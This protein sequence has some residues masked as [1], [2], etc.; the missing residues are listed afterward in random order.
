MA[1]TDM[2]WS[3]QSTY[4]KFIRELSLQN[5]VYTESL[6][7]HQYSPCPAVIGFF[8][9]TVGELETLLPGEFSYGFDVD[10]EI[11]ET[12]NKTLRL[13]VI[14]MEFSSSPQ[15]P[16]LYDA[17]KKHT[18]TLAEKQGEATRLYCMALECGVNHRDAHPDNFL[19]D[20]KGRLKLI[21]FGLARQLTEKEKVIPLIPLI[22]SDDCDELRDALKDLYKKNAWFLREPFSIDSYA[23]KISKKAV[24][25]CAEGLC[26]IIPQVDRRSEVEKIRMDTKAQK[27]VRE[28]TR[29]E[30]HQERLQRL[31]RETNLPKPKEGEE[32]RLQRWERERTEGTTEQDRRWARELEEER[33]VN[34]RSRA[35]RIL[36][37]DHVHRQHIKNMSDE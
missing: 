3:S 5:H 34:R 7:K 17:V 13:G 31:E 11:I 25:R 30:G 22:A 6:R 14:F 20:D 16:T 21:D 10:G 33:R 19:I 23:T 1:H 9:Y 12:E 29:K 36:L 37:Y 27:T 28:P 8:N 35:I 15:G 32:E 24:K 4:E 18:T 2:K 26:E